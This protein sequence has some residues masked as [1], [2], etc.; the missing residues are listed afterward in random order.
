[1][2][3]YNR[4][5]EIKSTALSLAPNLMNPK[6]ISGY[7]KRKFNEEPTDR[8]IEA[9]F[10]YL[11][12]SKNKLKVTGITE[13]DVSDNYTNI[14]IDGDE[15]DLYDD[16][17]WM[18]D[19]VK[20]MYRD[21]SVGEVLGYFEDIDHLLNDRDFAPYTE[22]GL[23]NQAENMTDNQIIEWADDAGVLTDDDFEKDEDDEDSDLVK[24]EDTYKGRLSLDILR[25]DWVHSELGDVHDHIQW[26]K[27]EYGDDAVFTLV[28]QG[29]V[30]L[31]MESFADSMVEGN[32]SEAVESHFGDHGLEQWTHEIYAVVK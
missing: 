29:D 26:Y 27:D 15:Y 24:N 19:Q 23:E 12:N 25:R 6:G 21:M 1:M 5:Y 13:V 10:D 9:I 22:A 32:E 3:R 11:K 20:D 16:F 28:R 7:I 18:V 2:L 30:D 17:D 14:T 8:I 4:L 31:D